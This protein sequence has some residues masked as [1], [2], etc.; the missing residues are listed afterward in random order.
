MISFVKSFTNFSVILQ[1]GNVLEG[2]VRKNMITLREQKGRSPKTS[3]PQNANA[4]EMAG[5][6]DS[7]I[8][9]TISSFRRPVVKAQ[10]YVS[11]FR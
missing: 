2:E 10:K 3:L 8:G 11:S 7:L 4:A 1:S 9:I 6:T 5:T